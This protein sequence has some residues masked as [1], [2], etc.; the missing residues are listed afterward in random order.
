MSQLELLNL[1]LGIEVRRTTLTLPTHL[2]PV[3]QLVKINISAEHEKPG[4]D[5][6]LPSP[7]RTGKPRSGDYARTFGPDVIAALRL[8]RQMINE[9]SKLRPPSSKQGFSVQS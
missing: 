7:H 9:R 2:N 6:L 8:L 4:G 5:Q 1:A 3:V